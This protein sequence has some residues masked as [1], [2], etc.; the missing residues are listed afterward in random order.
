M[1]D[2][3]VLNL[4]AENLQLLPIIIVGKQEM[5]VATPPQKL[6]IARLVVEKEMVAKHGI[7]TDLTKKSVEMPIIIDDHR[8]HLRHL[9]HNQ[10]RVSANSS[11]HF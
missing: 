10:L 1:I 6:I 7:K 8:L 11:F 9:F 4:A 5:L 3:L 2:K